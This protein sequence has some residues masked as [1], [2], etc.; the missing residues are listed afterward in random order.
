M[1][2]AGISDGDIA[3]IDKSVEAHNGSIV[4]AYVNNEFTIKFLDTT[5]RGEGYIELR[6]ANSQYAPIRIGEND[7]FEVWGVVIYTIKSW[8]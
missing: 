6:P 8:Q 5:H 2:E 3:V 7:A 1:I 4:V